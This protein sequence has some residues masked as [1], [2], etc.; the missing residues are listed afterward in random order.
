MS[1]RRIKLQADYS[2]SPLWDIENPDNIPLSEF[3]ISDRL[4]TRLENW[5]KKLEDGLDNDNP[6][7]YGQRKDIDFIQGWWK[8]FRREGACI[9]LELRQEI[10]KEY[11]VSYFVSRHGLLNDP[12]QLEQL[13]FWD[14]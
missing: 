6:G 12:Q 8:D 3:D 14:F 1:K 9:W 4:R 5:V 10:G 11:E 7:S 2:S 13:D